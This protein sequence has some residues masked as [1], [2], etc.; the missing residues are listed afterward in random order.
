MVH[1]SVSALLLQSIPTGM[2]KSF[3]PFL[4]EQWPHIFALM[5]LPLQLRPS[6]EVA[7]QHRARRS[8][9]AVSP[10]RAPRPGQAAQTAGQELH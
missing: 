8:R 3:S 10:V 7:A 9:H 2:L 1:A 4:E 6:A 5:H